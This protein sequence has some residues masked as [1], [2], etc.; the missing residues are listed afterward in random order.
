MSLINSN[1]LFLVPGRYPIKSKLRCFIKHCT[2]LRGWAAW[3]GL[4]CTA[5]ADLCIPDGFLCC[6][7]HFSPC[8]LPPPRSENLR[9]PWQLI[10][11]PQQRQHHCYGL[12][13]LSL[14]NH[15]DQSGVPSTSL[16]CRP[17]TDTW[18]FVNSL[19]PECSIWI[20]K[21]LQIQLS[22]CRFVD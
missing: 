3:T 21:L 2:V 8:L 4:L 5:H 17:H 7:W 11:F 16:L 18:A 19:V 14:L 15:K 12:G 20:R 13:P 1:L 9:C 10:Q 22:W 6:P